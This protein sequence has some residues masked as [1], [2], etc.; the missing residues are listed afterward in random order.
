MSPKTVMVAL[1]ERCMACIQGPSQ[2]ARIASIM[3][4]GKPAA[5]RCKQTPKTP[6]LFQI[7]LCAEQGD[8]VLASDILSHS[9]VSVIPTTLVTSS[10]DEL[11]K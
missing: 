5:L 6:R 7:R 3:I 2:S 1:N 8:R 4:L 9:F 10:F 11:R